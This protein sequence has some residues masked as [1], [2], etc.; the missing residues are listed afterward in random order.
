MLRTLHCAYMCLSRCLDF[1][2]ESSAVIAVREIFMSVFATFL[3]IFVFAFGNLALFFLLDTY[4]LQFIAEFLLMCFVC[5]EPL[6][7]TVCPYMYFCF[8]VSL[9]WLYFCTV[10][11]Q[12]AS[13]TAGYP[14]PARKFGRVPGQKKFPKT[15]AHLHVVLQK[16]INK[17]LKIPPHWLLCWNYCHR[18]QWI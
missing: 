17:R 3:T 11:A 9:L 13:R 14:S 2:S 8:S 6:L 10:G 1:A 5:C 18:W 4:F 15:T 16:K 7:S 12:A